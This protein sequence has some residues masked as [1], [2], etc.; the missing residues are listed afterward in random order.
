MCYILHFSN[1]PLHFYRYTDDEVEILPDMSETDELLVNKCV[2]SKIT[3]S[4]FYILYN[5]DVYNVFVDFKEAYDPIRR[6]KM[7]HILYDFGIP[8]KLERII[9]W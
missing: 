3:S 4:L 1:F 5:I 2:L 6:N 7:Y 8:A 9:G